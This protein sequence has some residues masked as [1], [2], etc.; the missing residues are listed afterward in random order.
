M[1]PD[2]AAPEFAD[3]LDTRPESAFHA[4]HHPRAASIPLE[5]LADRRHELPPRHLAFW[6]FDADPARAAAAV[7]QL[8]AD[9]FRVTTM[10]AESYVACRPQTGPTRAALWRPHRLL[11]DWIEHIEACLGGPRRAADL[12][13]GAGRDAVY[14]ARRGWSVAGYDLLPDALQR[15]ADLARRHGVHIDL[16]PADLEGGPWRC[17]PAVDLVCVFNFLH[18]PLFADIMAAIRPG[19]FAVADTFVEPQRSRYGKPRRER[20]VL[21]PNELRDAFS[22]WQITYYG[23]RELAPSRITAGLVARRPLAPQ[24]DQKS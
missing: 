22:G 3:I 19:G 18:R 17:E 9:G 13:C 24:S 21:R 5:Q 16:H 7:A 10:P 20:F 12:A 8:Q 4:G 11:A 1:T 14:L 23:E 2:S 6:V 15:A